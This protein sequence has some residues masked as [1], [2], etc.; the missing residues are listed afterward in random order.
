[1]IY[2]GCFQ[3]DI[4]PRSKSEKV[5]AIRCTARRQ[6]APCCWDELEG[7]NNPEGSWGVILGKRAGNTRE[8]RDIGRSGDYH[9]SVRKFLQVQKSLQKDL[10]RRM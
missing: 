1:M 5:M 8:K 7:R 10:N 4:P 6:T 3:A 9:G 2:T